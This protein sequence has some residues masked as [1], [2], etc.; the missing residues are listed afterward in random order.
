[1]S[2]AEL[3]DRNLEFLRRAFSYEVMNEKAAR[4]FGGGAFA[5][6]ETEEIGFGQKFLTTM[7]IL[8][9]FLVTG[10]AAKR[11]LLLDLFS[12]IRRKKIT[13][14]RAVVFLMSVEGFNEWLR[15]AE[16]YLG[17]FRETLGRIDPG[18]LAE[19]VT[20][21]EPLSAGCSENPR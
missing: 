3:F 20:S 8:D 19:T 7:F 12:M 10:N 14:G 2:A 17:D 4:L 16:S 15:H 21:G 6:P 9:R 11:R 18:P 13:P 5:R 1:M